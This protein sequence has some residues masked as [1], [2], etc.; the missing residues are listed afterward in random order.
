MSLV[1]ANWS[2]TLFA[3]LSGKGFTGSKLMDF[4]DA[5]GI[6][7]VTHVVGKG[8]TTT[9]VGLGPGA[10]AGIGTGVTALTSSVISAAIF[11]AAASAFGQTGSKL[12][13]VCDSIGDACVSEMANA[14]LTSTHAPVGVGTGVVDVGSVAVD[15]PGWGSDIESQGSGAG[16]IGS[17]WPNFATAIGIGCAQDVL[18]SGTGTVVISGGGA[19]PAAG[20]G[21]GT[22]S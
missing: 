17:E 11:N 18:A 5:V 7:S 4:T 1:G 9:D 3:S 20:V 6:G 10:G 13:D 2:N 14:T 16:F 21:V 8:F 15:A 12:Q 19:L 22:V